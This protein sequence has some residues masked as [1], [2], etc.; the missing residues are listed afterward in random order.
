MK[1]DT[2]WYDVTMP[3]SAEPVATVTLS[4]CRNCGQVKVLSDPCGFDHL[5]ALM[6]FRAAAA[7]PSHNNGGSD[8]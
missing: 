6:E 2:L 1:A 8:A 4:R 7:D 5:A 3:R